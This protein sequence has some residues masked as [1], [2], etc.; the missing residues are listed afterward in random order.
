LRVRYRKWGGGLAWPVAIS[1]RDKV[2]F[3]LELTELVPSLEA[4]QDGVLRRTEDRGGR[5]RD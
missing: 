2:A 4:G 5:S 1:P 3:L